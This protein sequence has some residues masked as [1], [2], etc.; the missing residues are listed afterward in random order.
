MPMEPAINQTP[1]PSVSGRFSMEE[2]LGELSE[3]EGIIEQKSLVISEQKKRIAL[4]EECLRLE[5]IR[6]YGASSEKNPGQGELFNE[7]EQLADQAEAEPEQKQTKRKKTGRKG[8]SEKIP[9]VQIYLKLSEEEKAGA[10][11]TFFSKVKEELDI[12]PA[13]VRVLEYLQEKA[14]FKTDEGEKTIKAAERPLHPLGKVIASINLLAY[15][16][17]AKYCDA[18]PL[19]RMEKILARYGG[20][21]TRTSM[22]N[23]IIRLANVLMPLINLMKEHQISGHYLQMDET[24]VQVLK[25]PGKSATSDKW[26]WEIRGGPPDQPVIIFEYDAS[27]SADVPSRLLAGFK[28]TLQTDGYSGYNRACKENGLI[29]IGCWDHARRKFTDAIKAM[30][31]KQKRSGKISKAEEALSSI[32]KLYAIERKI[33]DLGVEERFQYRQEKSLPI[34]EA[35]KPWL[36]TNILKVPKDSLTYKAMGYALNQWESLIGYCNDGR[37]H[38]SNIL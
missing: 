37:Y 38:I 3:K 20:D 13:K 36:E 34:L 32:Q 26:F 28:G 19:Y 21:I 5:K 4:L 24:R 11:D 7:A 31:T 17:V 15:L 22:A 6:R 2:L 27:R 8:L 25:E 35:F 16:I 1:E 10:I 18:L 9:R 29:R 30:P 12:V 33:K 23:W 14:V